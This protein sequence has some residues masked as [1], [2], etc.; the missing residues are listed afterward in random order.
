MLT[1]T[2]RNGSFS[3]CARPMIW[4]LFIAI[5]API[6]D[7]DRSPAQCSRN[8]ASRSGVQRLALGIIADS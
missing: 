4:F 2:P 8:S 3:R 7:A 5:F 1:G 6:C